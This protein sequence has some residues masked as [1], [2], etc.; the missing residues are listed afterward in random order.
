MKNPFFLTD[1]LTLSRS[2]IEATNRDE[3]LKQIRKTMAILGLRDNGLINKEM[4][5]SQPRLHQ[6]IGQNTIIKSLSIRVDINE[7]EVKLEF[8]LS[9]KTLLL[10]A[11]VLIIILLI[12]KQNIFPA[13][14]LYL[15]PFYL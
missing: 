14:F 7:N 15:F 9:V 2:E 6:G 3:I 10:I 1:K 8:K 13:Y 5:F 4:V 11:F 12:P